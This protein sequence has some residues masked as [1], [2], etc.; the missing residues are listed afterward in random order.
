MVGAILKATNSYFQKSMTF[1]RSIYVKKVTKLL[2]FIFE[3]P[4][5]NI[6]E[7]K[8]RKNLDFLQFYLVRAIKTS[9]S[10]E[11]SMKKSFISSRAALSLSKGRYDETF[12]G[13]DAFLWVIGEHCRPR[14]DA[15]KRH[16]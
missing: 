9:F 15:S 5:Y 7:F 12:A 1:C 8:S 10:V 13:E 3:Q 6:G 4:S 11:L 16:V 14:S 2:A